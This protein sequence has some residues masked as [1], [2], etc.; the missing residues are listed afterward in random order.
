MNQRTICKILVVAVII[1]F[2]GIGIQPAFAVTSDTS[3]S[4]DDC[5]LCPKKVSNQHYD[6]VEV[7]INILSGLLKKY[8][9]VEDIPV[10]LI[11][12]GDKWVSTAEN[13]LPVPPPDN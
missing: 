13:D 11:D 7:M 10:M 4:E 6:K 12:E 1:L 8:P 3:E 2:I 5:N 9:I